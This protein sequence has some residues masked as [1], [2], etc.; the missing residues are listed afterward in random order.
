MHRLRQMNLKRKPPKEN[1]KPEDADTKTPESENKDKA[2]TKKGAV[3]EKSADTNTLTAS[4]ND[5]TVTMTYGADA[6]IPEG[7]KLYVRG[8]YAL[9]SGI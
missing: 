8:N 9:Y 2:E 7:A 4:G 3:S 5:Y 1:V 6:E